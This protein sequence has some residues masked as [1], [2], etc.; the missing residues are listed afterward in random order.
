MSSTLVWRPVN[1]GRKSLSTELK[2]ILRKV[3][4][5]TEGKCLLSLQ[6]ILVL[7]G[8]KASGMCAV[9]ID[10]LLKAIEKHNAIEIEE[11]Y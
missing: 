10:V 6:D 1:A 3:Y 9:E 5:L 7:K 8:I 4:P 2:F 11:V